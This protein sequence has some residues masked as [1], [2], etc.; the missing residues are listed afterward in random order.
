MHGLKM[1]LQFP[2]SASTFELPLITAG[3]E[4][5]INSLTIK[6]ALWLMVAKADLGLGEEGG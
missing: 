2:I 1:D 6:A 5:R 4:M 3:L